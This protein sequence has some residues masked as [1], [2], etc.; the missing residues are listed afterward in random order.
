[1]RAQKLWVWRFFGC[2]C[3]LSGAAACHKPAPSTDQKITP[4]SASATFRPIA[5]EANQLDSVTAFDLVGAADGATVI[6]ADASSKAGFLRRAD[7]DRDGEPRAVAVS[8]PV[9]QRALGA[10]SDLSAVWIGQTLAVSWL[11]RAQTEARAQALIFASGSAAHVLDL[12]PAWFS[13]ATARGNVALASDAGRALVLARGREAA[14]ADAREQHCTGFSFFRLGPAQA[15]NVG[16]PMSVP[17]PCIENSAQLIAVGDRAHHGVCTVEQGEPV[18]TIFSIQY[19][20]EYARADQLLKG[21]K[22]LGMVEAEHTA[23][24]VG[25]CSGLRRAARVTGS[26]GPVEVADLLRPRIS[27]GP[28]SLQIHAGGFR[29]DLAAPRSGL[30]T[31]LPESM[32]PHL[33]RAAWTGAR[34]IVALPHGPGLELASYLCDQ[35][36]LRPAPPVSAP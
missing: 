14:C 6:W 3:A 19:H 20:P 9:G 29:L 23:W 26:D 32:A 28:G 25:D 17:V 15:E 2:F 7:L 27:C 4:T 33:S 18:T 1:M 22:P 8:L 24:L 35:G 30:Q 31:V 36:E 16:L 12:G 21:C 11:E 13:P 34:L 5:S 10:V